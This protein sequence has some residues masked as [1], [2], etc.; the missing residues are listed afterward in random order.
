MGVRAQ[1]AAPGDVMKSLGMQ[2]ALVGL[3][4]L[5]K[6]RVAAAAVPLT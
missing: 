1:E 5:C 2:E 3:V 6:E 4:A